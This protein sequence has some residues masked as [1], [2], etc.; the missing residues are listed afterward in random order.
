LIR[1]ELP[2]LC[3]EEQSRQ[4]EEPIMKLFASLLIFFALSGQSLWAA[5][6]DQKHLEKNP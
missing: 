3:S 6:P 4:R 5:T 2:A 1:G